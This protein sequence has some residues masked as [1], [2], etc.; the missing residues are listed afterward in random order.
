VP[1]RIRADAAKSLPEAQK[2]VVVADIW[3]GQI[4]IQRRFVRNLHA[5]GVPTGDRAALLVGGAV[6]VFLTAMR[7]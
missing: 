1:I 5:I 3:A 4:V 7:S 6:L 2:S